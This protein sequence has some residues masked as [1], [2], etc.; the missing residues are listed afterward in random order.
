MNSYAPKLLEFKKY[1]NIALQKKNYKKSHTYSCHQHKNEFNKLKFYYNKKR[2]NSLEN[3]RN[4]KKIITISE[5]NKY[6]FYYNTNI[7][8]YKNTHEY[9]RNYEMNSFNKNKYYYNSNIGDKPKFHM[10]KEQAIKE[11]IDETIENRFITIF[12]L[13]VWN[14]VFPKIV[15]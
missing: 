6:K 3:D 2:N 11:E 9:H 8:T 4:K 13:Y 7:D 14:S 1:Y 15:L 12:L 10:S 5:Y